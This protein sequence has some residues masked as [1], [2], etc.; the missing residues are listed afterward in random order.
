[1]LHLQNQRCA[2]S[3]ETQWCR[4][5][6]PFKRRDMSPS[7]WFRPRKQGKPFKTLQSHAGAALDPRSLL[8]F[9]RNAL[10]HA[11]GKTPANAFGQTQAM[12]KP[13]I[14]QPQRLKTAKRAFNKSKVTLAQP[15]TLDPCYAPFEMPFATRRERRQR[16]P[17]AKLKRCASPPSI[18]HSV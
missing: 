11:P 2:S 13:C 15:L 6:A 16:T 9:F 18:S 1:M 4:S 8:R 7:I 17:S 3:G 12:R 14:N 5:S 10:R